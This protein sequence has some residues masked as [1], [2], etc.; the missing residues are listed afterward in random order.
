MLTRGRGA[1]ARASPDTVFS[2]L[3][4]FFVRAVFFLLPADQRLRCSEVSR[5]WR[6]LLADTSLWS[7][8]TLST[9]SG[10]T[11]FSEALFRAV[12]AK[13]GGQLRV[14]DVY[15]RI[16]EELSTPTLLDALASNAT[17]LKLLIALSPSVSTWHTPAQ[18]ENLLEAAPLSLCFLNVHPDNVEQARRCL[19]NEPPYGRLRLDGL[20]VKGE[21]QLVSSESLEALCS[22]LVKH[23]TLAKVI[24]DQVPLCTAS[25]MR[26]FVNAAIAL[27][28]KIICL[29]SCG[30]TRACVP[31][32]TRLVSAGWVGGMVIS[33][34]DV[35]LFEAGADTDRFCA[36]VRASA[37]LVR[38]ELK[39][40]GPNPDVVA[41]VGCI[42]QC[43]SSVS[44]IYIR[45]AACLATVQAV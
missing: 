35:E 19:R 38:L 11:R 33:N 45:V 29:V 8:L 24:I 5:A 26:I 10:C 30:C 36:A 42:H 4:R 39:R 31:E 9:K 37:S 40:C 7:F 23:P 43:A 28:V 16:G 27:R 34:D 20:L 13:A 44:S 18:V 32:L 6:A 3:P 22:D 41:V 17:S 14:L 2:P 15:G 25:A 1:Q 21:G 12:V